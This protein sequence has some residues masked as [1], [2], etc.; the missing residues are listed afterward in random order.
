[1]RRYAVV[2]AAAWTATWIGTARAAPGD[3]QASFDAPCRY[4]TGLACDG[5]HLY[6]VDWRAARIFSINPDDGTVAKSWD[7]PTPKPHGLA[8]GGGKLFVSDDHTGMVYAVDLQTGEV[9]NPFEAPGPKGLGLAYHDGILFIL[10][11]KSRRIYKVLPEDGTILG[12][13]PVPDRSCACMTHDGTYLWVANR[14]ADE[15]YMVEPESGAVLNVL[16]A[17]GPYAAGLAWHGGLLY[18]ADFQQDK[19]YRLT[20]H[21]DPP[22]RLGDYRQARVEYLWALTNYGPG[23]VRDLTVNLAVPDELPSQRLLSPIE[24]SVPPATTGRDRWGQRCAVVEIGSIPPG[25]KQTVS[26]TVSADIRAIRYLIMPDKAGTLDDIPADIRAP[27]TADGSR[28]RITTPYMV[29]TVHRIVGEE[30]NAYWIARK[31]YDYLIE[32]IEYEMI[33]G[34]DVP[35]VVLK[36]GTGSCSEYTF[37]FVALCRAAGLPARYQ[38]SVVMRNDDASIDEAFHR[39]AQVYLPNY[40][41]VP[42]DASRGDSPSPV[43]QCRGFGTLADHFLITT[44]SGG[45]SEFL[46]WGY[47]SEATYKT[48]GYCKT[49]VDTFGFWEPLDAADGKSVRTEDSPP[50]QCEP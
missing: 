27:Y 50:Q 44:H 29:D 7:A 19:I 39:W 41:W 14:V 43:E 1:M 13:F 49:E 23:E 3:V 22:Y 5:E 40:G 47:N 35:E 32:H 28:Y 16:D 4:P 21:G 20:I 45:D 12:Y 30:K 25:S 42:V 10:E 8:C 33:G 26:Y 6:V 24:Y 36:R 48:T 15:I 17:P 9:G 31:I 38:G 46:R 18:N 11:G 2:C 37:C 34:W